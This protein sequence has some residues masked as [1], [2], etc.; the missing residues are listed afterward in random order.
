MTTPKR[1]EARESEGFLIQYFIQSLNNAQYV[2]II[3]GLYQIEH[4]VIFFSIDKLVGKGEVFKC[5][6]K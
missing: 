1:G 3:L 4:I 2:C 6:S 5:P